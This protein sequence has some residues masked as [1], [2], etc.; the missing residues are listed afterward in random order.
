MN[1]HDV[2]ALLRL[3]PLPVEGGYFKELYR[4][5][6]TTIYY[7]ITPDN[8]S[9]FHKLTNDEIYHFY[10]GDPAEQF[11]IS[12]EGHLRRTIVGANLLDSH[13]PVAIVPREYWQATRLLPGGKFALLGC[14]VSPAFQFE[15]CE[16]AVREKLASDF[17]DHWQ[18]ISELTRPGK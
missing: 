13:R 4:D 12:P 14:T 5:L 3:E 9:A 15:N 1:A 2:I 17:S 8:F 10:L 18:L 7:L 16:H 6:C 11:T